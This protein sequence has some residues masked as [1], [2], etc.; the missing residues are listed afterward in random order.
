MKVTQS[1]RPLSQHSREL[2]RSAT[3]LR[4]PQHLVVTREQRRI[5]THLLLATS[6]LILI[7]AGAATVILMWLTVLRGIPAT[8]GEAA[9]IS[10]L[11][12]GAFLT[13]EGTKMNDDGTV[14]GKLVALTMTTVT[15]QLVA[16]S[17][18]FL[19]AMMAYCVAGAWLDEQQHPNDGG[20]NLPTPL[21]YG[22]LV[23]L[24]STAG[25]MAL[26]DT[27]KYFLSRGKK[28]REA[29]PSLLTVAFV[30]VILI[31]GL[32]HV[33]TI[34]D[35]WLHL[36][37]ATILHN[38]T[39]PF[40]PISLDV[41][42]NGNDFRFGVAFNDSLCNTEGPGIPTTVCL[43]EF[44]GWAASFPYVATAGMLISSNTSST[45]SLDAIS[46]ISSQHPLSVITLS[47]EQDLAVLVPSSVNPSIMWSAPTFGIRSTCSSI[48]QSCTIA[49]PSPNNPST[50]LISF[51]CTD[52]GYPY[53]PYD[54]DS[55]KTHNL[56]SANTTGRVGAMLDG[57]VVQGALSPYYS[58]GGAL[59]E[60]P[61]SI[62]IEMDWPTSISIPFTESSDVTYEPGL[63]AKA[64]MDCQMEFFNLTVRHVGGGKFEVEGEM[65]NTTRNF[66]AV[67]WE[68]LISQLV[69]LQLHANLQARALSAG[70]DDDFIAALNQELSRLSLAMFGGATISAPASD[71]LI[72]HSI[73]VGRYPVTPVLVYAL[74]LY[75]Y[76][77]IVLGICFWASSLETPLVKARDGTMVP[78]LA[79]AQNALTDPL[80]LVGMAFP[81][82]LKGVRGSVS[83]ETMDMFGEGSR[84]SH[85]DGS[86][87]Q[88]RDS[89]SERS[90]VDLELGDRDSE[91]ASP[92]I[93]RLRLGVVREGDKA[94][95]MFGVNESG[96]A[97]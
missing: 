59:P 36:T 67:M 26:Y 78:S 13:T 7:S 47:D 52:A 12:T 32:T 46:G 71:F 15:S 8:P 1:Q 51:N 66:T 16:I 55:W 64:F 10:A 75:I 87:S 28:K 41:D 50:M 45:S 3:L 4:P 37:S 39:V 23:K 86:G 48:T 35:L 19:V 83:K 85:G 63:D 90:A 11:K 69:N 43:T 9:I 25:I 54:R 80:V 29:L 33:I 76:S 49:Q 34:T 72:T 84:R 88:S 14:N 94:G 2:S 89:Q 57:T 18:P 65:E 95:M 96:D 74:L 22:L 97:V 70:S 30:S 77:M 24:S 21:Q 17:S 79:L 73:L 68:P 31:Y 58:N 53:V 81:K 44:R 82:S 56:G 62:Q 40:S 6:A 60:N 92:S 91:D 27:G 42:P 93:P 5:G 20:T 61:Q 38:S